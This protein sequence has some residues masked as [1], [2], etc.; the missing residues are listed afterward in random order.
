MHAYV[1]VFTCVLFWFHCESLTH[2][3][4]LSDHMHFVEVTK[5]TSVNFFEHYS[6]IV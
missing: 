1:C 6:K 4:L 2:D 5:Q 3:T